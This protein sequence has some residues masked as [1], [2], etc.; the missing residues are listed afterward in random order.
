M[1]DLM[2]AVYTRAPVFFQTTRRTQFISSLIES[3]GYNPQQT[4]A[5]RNSEV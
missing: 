3:W 1:N 2:A 5:H 4:H